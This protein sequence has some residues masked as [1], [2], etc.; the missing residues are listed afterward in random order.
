[1][2]PYQALFG[3]LPPT[4]PPYAKGS[5]SIQVLEDILLECST[6]L[7][8]LKANLRQAQHRMAQK[9]NAHRR[10]AHFKVEDKV[11][12]KLQPYRQTT[13]AF[14]A[15]QKLAKRYYGPFS[16]LARVGSVAY[17]LELP[18]TSKIHSVFHISVLKPYHGNNPA[19]SHPLP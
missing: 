18:S 3:R 4:I 16:V 7:Q 14:R 2:S 12:V 11:L 6:L 9:A 1:M 8:S 15:C 19:I 13:I 10:E 5:T 17:K